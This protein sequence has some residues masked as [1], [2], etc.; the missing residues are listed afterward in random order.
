MRLFA[1]IAAFTLV[2][3]AAHAEGRSLSLNGV[4][5][6]LPG[7][8]GKAAETPK[9]VE[10]PVPLDP[11][12]PPAPPPAIAAPAVAVPPP[13]VA[14][15]APTVAAPAIAV[16]APTVEAPKAETP[17]YVQRPS[18]VGT[19]PADSKEGQVTFDE[20]KPAPAAPAT[21]ATTAGPDKSKQAKADK[22]RRKRAHWDEARIMR[23]IYRY[24]GYA[25]MIGGW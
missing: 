5:Q 12:R 16:P 1:L 20:S 6:K 25:G 21:P 14:A 23:E 8:L 22:P 9:I 4:D 13:A 11:P 18:V 17:A 10:A 7:S 2:S 15:P 19:K 24:S 3:F